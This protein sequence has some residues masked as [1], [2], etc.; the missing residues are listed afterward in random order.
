MNPKANPSVP[1]TV[2]TRPANNKSSVV[3]QTEKLT[4]G[5]EREIVAIT[6]PG[7]LELF[8]GHPVVSKAEL[9]PIG[10]VPAG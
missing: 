1:R 5:P 3:T 6:L 8:G 10:N 7:F 4:P 2:S 9:F